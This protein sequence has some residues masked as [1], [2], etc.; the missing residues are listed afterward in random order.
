[1]RKVSI[2]L[3]SFFLS[4]SYHLGHIQTFEFAFVTKT[5]TLDTF[6]DKLCSSL[7]KDNLTFSLIN[8]RYT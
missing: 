6:L 3:H 5:G 8:G 4:V 1:M 7:V 2:Q